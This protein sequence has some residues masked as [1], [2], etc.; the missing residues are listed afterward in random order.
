[1]ESCANVPH[2]AF[3]HGD[4]TYVMLGK[5]VTFSGV[6]RI[7]I[8]DVNKFVI[9]DNWKLYS[10]SFTP[11]EHLCDPGKCPAEMSR[12]ASDQDNTDYISRSGAGMVGLGP[13][14]TDDGKLDLKAAE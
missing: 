2:I 4:Q 7:M 10:D 5:E 6:T 1:M 11:N 8:D 9:C 12:W 14:G 3:G 13:C